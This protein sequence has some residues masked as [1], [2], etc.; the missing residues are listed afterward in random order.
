MTEEVPAAPKAPG[1][2]IFAAVLN[3]IS[4]AFLSVLSIFCI[5]ALVFGNI[6]GVYDLAA[7]QM[8][9]AN[10]SF[11]FTFLFAV[12]LLTSAV[13]LV[14]FLLVGLGLLKGKKIAWY[15]QIGMSVF[16]LLTSFVAGLAG[17]SFGGVLNAALLIF[18][19]QPRVRDY[20][21]V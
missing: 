7:R 10:L 5:L 11:G 6:L 18:F 12:I 21:K 19:F 15:L 20:F 4:V 17:I 16:G 2:V 9:A 13:F 14:F 8:Q 3:F 1:V